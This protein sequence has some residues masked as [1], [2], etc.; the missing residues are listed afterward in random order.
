MFGGG[1]H[2]TDYFFSAFFHNAAIRPEQGLAFR[3]VSD[4]VFRLCV[5]FY[6]SGKTR[7]SRADY[8]RLAYLVKKTHL[9]SS[10][11]FIPVKQSF[12][13]ILKSP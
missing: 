11:F 10:L 2:G 9:S 4:E 3:A 1:K 7:A 13:T 8:A 6:M 5:Q 12:Y